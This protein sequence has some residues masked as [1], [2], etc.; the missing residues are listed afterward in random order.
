MLEHPFFAVTD[1]QRPLLDSDTA[2]GHLHDRGRGTSGSARRHQ[3]VTVAA[4]ETQRPDVHLQGVLT[5]HKRLRYSA[6]T[7]ARIRRR[8][9]VGADFVSL[10]KPRLNS[11]VLDHECRRVLPGRRSPCCPGR[12]LLHTL[13]GTAL[14]AGGASAL[15]QFWER[16]TDRLDAAHAA[17]PAA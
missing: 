8:E 4:Q 14:V 15:N 16:D 13:V 9:A 1:E 10:T 3:Q 11:L 17:A 12:H 5:W 7:A 6:A 2:A